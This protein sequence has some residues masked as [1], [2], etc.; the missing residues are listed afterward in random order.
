MTV[1][2][3]GRQYAVSLARWL[4]PFAW[5]LGWGAIAFVPL[6]TFLLLP[7]F[8]EAERAAGIKYHGLYLQ[9]VGFW[10][11]WS[12]I[13]TALTAHKKPF[14]FN[15]LTAWWRARPRLAPVV[16]NAAVGLTGISSANAQVRLRHGAP[17]GTLEDRVRAAEKNIAEL[18]AEH[19]ALE[20]QLK[21]RI[22]RAEKSVT[23]EV[24]AREKAVQE[25]SAQVK[26]VAVGSAHQQIL[27]LFLFVCG[28]VFGTVP[29]LIVRI[30]S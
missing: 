9:V 3:R 19:D 16:V 25:V 15:W 5:V 8:S 30:A 12:Q 13:Q 18:T 22:S 29:E 14:G 26:N 11:T 4:E 27:G 17:S 23:E 2:E 1:V 21:G 24:A 28:A 10:L 20:T 7:G 6:A